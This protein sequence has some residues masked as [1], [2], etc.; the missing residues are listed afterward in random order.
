ME[1]ISGEGHQEASEVLTRALVPFGGNLPYSRERYQQEIHMLY[2]MHGIMRFE[3]GRRLIVMWEQE[4]E[5]VRTFGQFLNKFFPDLDRQRAYEDMQYAVYAE[6]SP[7]FKQFAEGKGNWSKALAMMAAFDEEKFAEFEKTG[8]IL[9]LTVDELD[10]LS[11]SELKKRVRKLE[12]GQ[13]KAV[14][15]ATMKVAAENAGLKAENEDLKAALAEPGVESVIKVIR[16]AEDKLL[17]VVKLIRK[18][19]KTILV[20]E[21]SLRQ[22]VFGT[23]GNLARLLSDLEQLADEA[24]NEAAAA[25][26]GE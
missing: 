11:L 5:V 7:L 4:R 13:D 12:Q 15:D 1:P 10:R 8:E 26:A 19:P 17:E 2:A 16:A 25:E 20:Q 24:N 3:I 18:I 6:K 22:M 23:T 21:Q 14:H 9:G